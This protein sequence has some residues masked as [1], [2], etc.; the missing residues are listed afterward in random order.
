M[1]KTK[2]I[3]VLNGQFYLFY[4]VPGEKHPNRVNNY[5]PYKDSLNMTGIYRISCFNKK[6][7]QI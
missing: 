1:F 4:P 6:Y 7:W 5:H 2:I 3:K